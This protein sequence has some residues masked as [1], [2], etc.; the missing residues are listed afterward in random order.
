MKFSNMIWEKTTYINEAILALPFNQELANGTLA[1][2]LFCYYIEQD[3]NYLL[4]FAKALAL[5]AGRVQDA[6]IMS[7]FLEFSKSALIAEQDVVHHHYINLFKY[8]KTDGITPAC[9]AYTNFLVRHATSSSVEIAI[10]AVLPC[11]WIYREVGKHIY[12]NYSREN[13]PYQKWIETYASSEFDDTVKKAIAIMDKYAET[14]TETTRNEM[15][16]SFTQSSLM[17][18]HFWNDAYY[19]RSINIITSKR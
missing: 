10:A 4:D 13:N 6:V 18:W 1:K 11:F 12:N 2:D 19:K 8:K 14:T 9:F 7:D 16:K 17:E 3:A 5:I 15:E